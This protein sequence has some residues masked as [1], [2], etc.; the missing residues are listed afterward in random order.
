MHSFRSVN[1][2]AFDFPLVL[3]PKSV[4]DNMLK[5]PDTLIQILMEICE[6]IKRRQE[7]AEWAL[8]RRFSPDFCSSHARAFVKNDGKCGLALS[9]AT[10]L[11][12]GIRSA[13]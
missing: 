5:S 2:P 4:D 6:N 13:W 7:I 11:A 9:R 10:T 12:I 3:E 8:Q 1:T